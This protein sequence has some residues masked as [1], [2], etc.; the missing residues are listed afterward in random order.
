MQFLYVIAAGGVLP[1]YMNQPHAVPSSQHH[2][3]KFHTTKSVEKT[4]NKRLKSNSDSEDEKIE[5]ITSY[6]PTS[7][8][9]DSAALSPAP[10]FKKKKLESAKTT[11]KKES[12]EEM[13]IGPQLPPDYYTLMDEDEDERDKEGEPE[14]R[15]PGV[16][17]DEGERLL[18]PTPDPQVIPASQPTADDSGKISNLR[19]LKTLKNKGSDDCSNGEGNSSSDEEKEV[20]SG[21]KKVVNSD[22]DDEV[23]DTILERLKNQAKILQELGGEIPEEIRELIKPPQDTEVNVPSPLL[24]SKEIET[25]SNEIVIKNEISEVIKINNVIEKSEKTQNSE[26]LKVS[27]S[28]AMPDQSKDN[29][30]EK[31]LPKPISNNTKI[32]EILLKEKAPTSFSLIA[33]Y[34]NEDDSEI[35]EDKVEDKPKDNDK[36]KPLFPILGCE[37]EK[38]QSKSSKVKVIKLSAKAKELIHSSTTTGRARATDF[39]TTSEGL[40]PAGSI[41]KENEEEISR[42]DSKVEFSEPLKKLSRKKRIE[43]PVVTKEEKP[44]LPKISVTCDTQNI[45]NDA[46]KV[47][48][49]PEATERPATMPYITAWNY[50]SELE[51]GEHRG[52]GYGYDYISDKKPSTTVKKGMIQFV[53]A[54]TLLPQIAPVV[55][56]HEK[57]EPAKEEIKQ[58]DEAQK[59]QMEQTTELAQVISEKVKFLCEGK[60]AVPPVQVMAIQLET[61]VA[62]LDAGG[63][64]AK[65][66][67]E[68]LTSVDSQLASLEQAA[69]PLGWQCQWD[70]SYKRYFYRN[71]ESGV[72][73]WE[74]P[75]EHPSQGGE[76]AMELCDSPPPPPAVPAPPTPPPPRISSRSPSPPVITATPP[77]PPLPPSPPVI[78]EQPPLPPLP[79]SE[80]PPPPPLPPSPPPP[81]PPPVISVSLHTGEPLPPGVDMPEEMYEANQPPL[82]VAPPPPPKTPPPP[83]PPETEPAYT[84]NYDVTAVALHYDPY[85]IQGGSDYTGNVYSAEASYSRGGENYVIARPPASNPPPNTACLA[86]ELDS[87]YNEVAALDPPPP[88]PAPSPSP[89]PPPSP[90]PA[91]PAP[92]EPTKKR[93]KTKLTPGLALKKKGVS[94]LV[95]KWQQVQQDVRREEAKEET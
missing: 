37:N 22:E 17:D 75:S 77:L 86:S 4:K 40:R 43:I 34:G 66:M 80:S 14:P 70:R 10:S 27:Q 53:K 50:N 42:T 78:S 41:T 74:Y 28:F 92:A 84:M 62:A 36:P 3:K 2:Q 79:P 85:Q 13:A 12:K 6:G 39:I 32:E 21:N 20:E 65:Y 83:P 82:P 73:Q 18:T 57:K 49:N 94:S 87:F 72:I 63:L 60:E 52:F 45:T 48:K 8:E 24:I 69:A 47:V 44:I 19:R 15:P 38:P 67:W 76:E 1:M 58:E 54:D 5:L 30:I 91:Q 71:E 68:W 51:R 90:P 46:P 16:E 95:A 26:S 25:K 11:A 31:I 88:P 29:N 55:T 64:S 81:P 23:E 35:E 56:L 9:E 33:G 7:D 93:K 59:L 61:L 89:P